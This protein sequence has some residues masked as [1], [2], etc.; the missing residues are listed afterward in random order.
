MIVERT[1]YGNEMLNQ[2]SCHTAALELGG[3][4]VTVMKFVCTGGECKSL[5]FSYH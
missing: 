3:V 5:I 1:P 4:V 2:K